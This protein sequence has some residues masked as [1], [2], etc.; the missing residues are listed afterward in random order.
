METSCI[1]IEKI[2]HLTLK[3]DKETIFGIRLKD[4]NGKWEQAKILEDH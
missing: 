2:I 3:P 1:L 4:R